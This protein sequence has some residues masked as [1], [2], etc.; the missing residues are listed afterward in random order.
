[1]SGNAQLSVSAKSRLRWQC[2]RGMLELDNLLLAFYQAYIANLPDSTLDFTQNRLTEE[3]L[4][5]FE[6]L[7]QCSDSLL[8]EYLMGRIVPSD[9][10]TADVVDKIRQSVTY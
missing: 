10:K 9:R 4:A 2:R 5:A 6:T 1:M 7:L 8:L 3:E